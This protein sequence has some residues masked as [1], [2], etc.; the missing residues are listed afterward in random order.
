MIEVGRKPIQKVYKDIINFLSKG[1][2]EKNRKK[3][4][5]DDIFHLF[6]LAKLSNGKTYKLQ[7]NEVVDLKEATTENSDGQL[8]KV[9]LKNK[10]LTFN[11]I[12]EGTQKILGAK[13]FL[14]DSINN[15]CQCWITSCLKGVGLLTPE[16]N[17][18][19][20]QDAKG[21]IS[22]DPTFEK[23]A[24]VATNL[25]AAW[26]R[27]LEGEGIMQGGN[28]T[29]YNFDRMFDYITDKGF[30]L[31]E[32]GHQQL[33]HD[34]YGVIRYIEGL[35]EYKLITKDEYDIVM[36]HLLFSNYFPANKMSG[37]GLKG[38]RVIAA[39]VVRFNAFD[40]ATLRIWY[41]RLFVGQPNRNIPSWISDHENYILAFTQQ[42][43]DIYDSFLTV[44]MRRG[45]ITINQ[46][47][48]E[49]GRV[50][51]LRNQLTG[52]NRGNGKKTKNS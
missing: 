33:S 20:N 2:F 47:Q 51:I 8:M 1:E 9:N 37:F 48:H 13:T 50:D 16:L 7:K 35:L 5:Y 32:Y 34:F 46:Y 27:I 49:L 14:Y 41:T 26:N 23:L 12:F 30:E 44:A 11:M 15:N 42:D 22:H 45:I 38:G 29:R 19:I 31:T 10:K 21:L 17:K 36:K 25:G 40:N 52:L 39:E 18:F 4:G 28:L 24:K 43:E 3:F 6:L